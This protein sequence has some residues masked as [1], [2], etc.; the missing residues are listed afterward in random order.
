LDV[1]VRRLQGLGP[2]LDVECIHFQKSGVQALCALQLALDKARSLLHYCADS[3]KLYLAIK[4]ETMLSRFQE[5]KEGL[6]L[7]LR[8]ISI[9]VPQE[10]SAQILEIQVEL[11]QT[12]F[13]LDPS[14]KQ[15][16]ADII[17]LLLQKQKGDRYENPQ[18]EQETFSQVVIQLGLV[19]ADSILVEKHALKRLLEKARHEGDSRKEAVT[20][21]ILQLM[22]KFNN[23]LRMEKEVLQGVGEPARWPVSD[24]GWG[25][26]GKLST[27]EE[28]DG[29]SSPSFPSHHCAEC[30][31][32]EL[33]STPSVSNLAERD[34]CSSS[35]QTPRTS[36]PPEELRCPI[37]LQLMSDPVIVASGQTYERVCIEKWFQVSFW[38]H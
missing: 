8:R 28:T 32:S 17:S 31:C 33:G 13:E 4:G 27:G 25:L 12:Q 5:V 36:L 15:I 9:L 18:A 29:L 35:P 21:N 14:E 11:S 30:H 10:L 26:S 2:A 6:E 24:W 19:S 7:S 20:R 3:S 23:I 22:K 34:R 16:G 37:S 38:P 1:F